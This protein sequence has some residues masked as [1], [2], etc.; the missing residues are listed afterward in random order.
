[1]F[2]RILASIVIAFF[3]IGCGSPR[4]DTSSD[5]KMKASIEEI[6]KSLSDEK[7]K[8][9]EDALKVVIFSN[10]ALDFKSI[11]ALGAE[12]TAQKI[13]EEGK[14]LISNKTADEVILESKKN[15]RKN[16]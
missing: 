15:K 9:F 5:E 14:A 16:I 6:K 1:M 3:I 12:G 10:V 13:K 4:I 2:K 11:F 7:R 8:D